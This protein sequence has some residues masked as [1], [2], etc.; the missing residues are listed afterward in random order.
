MENDT[1]KLLFSFKLKKT[2][3]AKTTKLD[4]AV[5]QIYRIKVEVTDANFT[6]IIKGPLTS[7]NLTTAATAPFLPSM[8]KYKC[9]IT[10]YCTLTDSATKEMQPFNEVV[11]PILIFV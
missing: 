8:S 4:V 2:D 10:K 7:Q 6:K 5:C 3:K 11:K 9:G 1:G